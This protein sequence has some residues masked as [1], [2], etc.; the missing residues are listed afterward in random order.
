[1]KTNSLSIFY[2]VVVLCI[3]CNSHDQER[4]NG[5]IISKDHELESFKEVVID[6]NFEVL[7]NKSTAPTLTITT[8]ENLHEF[9]EFEQ[10]R[11]V[12]T[13]SSDGELKSEDGIK[14]NINYVDLAGVSSSGANVI[15]G[16]DLISGDFLKVN[17]SGAGDINL[18]VELKA[19]KVEISGAGSVELS[20]SVMA[21][22]VDM[23]GA[24]NLKSYDLISQECNIDMSGVGGAT[25]HVKKKLDAKV[26]G[27]GGIRYIGD[28]AEVVSN[29][30]G[31]GSIT[32]A[33]QEK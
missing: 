27:V 19:L 13:I 10:K 20:G 14:L 1:M 6:G 33:D 23:S 4:G 18:N 24:G 2:L 28:P 7:L 11:D 17:M 21:C 30:S 16:N 22:N 29:I 12:L 31:L 26:S 32:K 5:N 25:L 8:D 15:S 3:S 9:I